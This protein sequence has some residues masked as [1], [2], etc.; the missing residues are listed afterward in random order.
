MHIN[1]FK[2]YFVYKKPTLTIFSTY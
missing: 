2:F 1:A